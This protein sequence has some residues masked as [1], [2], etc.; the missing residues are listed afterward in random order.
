MITEIITEDSIGKY[1]KVLKNEE[2]F[3]ILNGRFSC[4]GACDEQTGLPQGILSAEIHM[5]YIQVRR[6]YVLPGYQEEDVAAELLE[7]ITDLPE[8]LKQPILYYEVEDLVDE[9]LLSR[10]GFTEVKCGCS[11]IEGDLEHYKEIKAPPMNF[12]IGTLDQASPDMVRAFILASDY[13]KFLQIPD[14]YPDATRFSDGSLVIMAHGKVIGVILLEEMDDV[15]R[16]P[17]IHAKSNVEL[18]YA[19][20]V[21]RKVLLSEYSLKARVQFLMR[22]G[23]G[24]EA[25]RVLMDRGVEK[26]IRMFR[27]EG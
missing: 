8:E 6:V 23:I 24:R 5:E 17:Y 7:I 27:Y 14:G 9:S 16:V 19:L 3:G 10:Y 13:D 21:L 11:L 12:S 1:I 25:I 20:H 26:K 18:L 15:I 4:V 2:I 22:D